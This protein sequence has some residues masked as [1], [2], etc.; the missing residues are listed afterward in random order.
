MSMLASFILWSHPIES[1]LSHQ[2]SRRFGKQP[3]MANKGP[4]SKD[5]KILIA[6]NY[7]LVIFS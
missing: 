7:Q 3:Q 1:T 5:M 2:K 4:F 6:F